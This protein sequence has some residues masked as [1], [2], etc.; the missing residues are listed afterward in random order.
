MSKTKKTIK[1][2]KPRVPILDDI[3]DWIDSKAGATDEY[4]TKK[5][6]RSFDTEDGRPSAMDTLSHVSNTIMTLPSDVLSAV[7][8]RKQ[9]RGDETDNETY[10]ERS[11]TV[12]T[13][14]PY[15]KVRKRK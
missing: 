13:K 2:P 12:G 6:N 3:N 8:G 11:D 15:Y 1:I 14:K 10:N 9:V 4:Y 5:K 7:R